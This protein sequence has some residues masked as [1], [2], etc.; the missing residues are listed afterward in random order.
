MNKCRLCEHCA[1]TEKG[2]RV[3][4]KYLIYIGQG[5]YT[6]CEGPE[7]RIL[8]LK[9]AIVAGIIAAVLLSVLFSQL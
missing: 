2:E 3:C 9:Q 1:I 4:T 7:Y 6:Y 5:P 8:S